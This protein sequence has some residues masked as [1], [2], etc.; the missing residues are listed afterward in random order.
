MASTSLSIVTATITGATVTA[1]TGVASSQ[2][3]TL[4][5]TTAQ[6][7]IDFASLNV[8]VYNTNSTAS[9]T[10]AI[11]VGTEF[12]DIGIGAASVT[13]GTEATIIIGG[14]TFDG[15][16]FQTTAETIVFT[17]TGTG[18]TSWEAYQAPSKIAG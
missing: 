1:K 6:S 18:P 2:T 12:S 11:G 3:L 7:V 10:L 17:Q 16:R 5:A 15:S 14:K 8:R 13:V 9:V 4:S